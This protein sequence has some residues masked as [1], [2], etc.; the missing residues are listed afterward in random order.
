[1][2]KENKIISVQNLFLDKLKDSKKV[3][4]LHLINGIILK[5][6]ILKTDNF[7]LLVDI[8]NKNALIYKHSIAYIK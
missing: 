5:C 3:V 8:N 6:K 4:E 7:S 2:S 1:M